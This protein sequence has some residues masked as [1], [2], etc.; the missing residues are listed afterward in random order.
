M[1]CV[2]YKLIQPALRYGQNIDIK[3]CLKHTQNNSGYAWNIEHYCTQNMSRYAWN[4]DIFIVPKTL[5]DMLETSIVIIKICLKHWPLLY[6][7]QCKICSF[8]WSCYQLLVLRSYSNHHRLLLC[9]LYCL[10]NYVYAVQRVDSWLLSVVAT[11]WPAMSDVWH[12][13]TPVLARDVIIGNS[14]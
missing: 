14:K 11:S 7:K 5:P 3:M 12:H 4:T 9:L 8:I 10:C 2:Q 13:I 6:P 1:T